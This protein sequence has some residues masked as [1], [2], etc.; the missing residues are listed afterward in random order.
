M[1]AAGRCPHHDCFPDRGFRWLV[2]CQQAIIEH[3]FDYGIAV[4]EEVTDAQL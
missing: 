2:S 3:M 4:T 1:R